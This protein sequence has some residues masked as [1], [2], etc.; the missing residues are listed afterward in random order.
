MLLSY[1]LPPESH[2]Y[3][4]C[5]E[6]QNISTVTTGSEVA[7]PASSTGF[8]VVAAIVLWPNL[9]IFFTASQEAGRRAAIPMLC[10]L[11]HARGSER[12]GHRHAFFQCRPGADAGRLA[13]GKF[14]NLPASTGSSISWS[15]RFAA[16]ASACE[17]CYLQPTR[18]SLTAFC[19]IGSAH[20]FYPEEHEGG[21]GF[22][23]G[24]PLHEDELSQQGFSRMIRG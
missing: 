10:P 4:C 1:P 23:V 8:G 7:R 19:A 2:T 21:L 12:R 5:Q 3:P 22:I 17:S 13:A 9:S 6:R 16:A 11:A 14:L 18:V 24:A 15:R 20:T